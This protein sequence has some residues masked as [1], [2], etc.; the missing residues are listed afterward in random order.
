MRDPPSPPLKGGGLMPR[1]TPP[2]HGAGRSL[3]STVMLHVMLHV[4]LIV[5]LIVKLNVK[6]T[7]QVNSL[8]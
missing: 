8:N 2:P 4:M 5:K 1:N 6:H 7:N 3:S